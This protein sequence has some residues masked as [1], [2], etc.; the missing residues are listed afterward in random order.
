MIRHNPESNKPKVSGNSCGVHV[1]FTGK[2]SVTVEQFDFISAQ[3]E[4]LATAVDN[5]PVWIALHTMIHSNYYRL[6][7]LLCIHGYLGN[8]D[9][10]VS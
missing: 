6:S 7:L 4:T 5:G 3:N 10:V 1:T 9:T 2:K 8:S